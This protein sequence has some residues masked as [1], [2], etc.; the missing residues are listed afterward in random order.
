MLND[1]VE[2]KGETYG[3]IHEFLPV[4]RFCNLSLSRISPNLES[5][6]RKMLS[7]DA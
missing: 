6:E 1:W 5:W 7:Y 2:I 4:P 3:P